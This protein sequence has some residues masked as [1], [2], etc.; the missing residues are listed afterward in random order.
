MPHNAPPGAYASRLIETR[1]LSRLGR[2]GEFQL[3]H[4]TDFTLGGGDRIAIT[5]PSGSGKSVFLRTLA[6]LDALDAGDILWNG[7]PVTATQ[8]PRYRSRV[9][10]LAQRPS[11][12][13]GT[14]E[15]NL[16]FPYSLTAFR[17]QTFDSGKATRLLQQAG[18]SQ[19]FL[20]K[21]AGDLSGGESQVVSLI[22]SIQ[23]DPQVLLLD[24]P[25]AALDPQSSSDVET[26]VNSWFAE[27]NAPRAFIW[28]S[29]DL[30]QAE[31]MSNQH[32]EMRAGRLIATG[33]S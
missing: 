11:L 15:D 1:G 20:L 16:R 7:A 26:L 5:G 6:L 33:H 28:V 12:I 2:R 32:F 18:K 30:K 3:L 24:E 13:E 4:P 21:A 9:S 31:R 17:G 19:S 10:Y 8:V 27:G 14:V 22:R 23:M 25:T 29:H